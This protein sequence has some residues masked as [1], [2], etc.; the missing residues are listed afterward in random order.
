M[1][2]LRLLFIIVCFQQQSTSAQ[3][4]KPVFKDGEFSGKIYQNYTDKEGYTW[5]STDQGVYR[6]DS[7]NFEHFTTADGL[8]H[9]EVFK[10]YQDT[11]MRVWMIFHNGDVCYYYQGNIFNKNNFSRLQQLPKLSSS[12]IESHNSLYFVLKTRKYNLDTNFTIST[13]TLGTND[14]IKVI[15]KN[16]GNGVFKFSGDP[17][18]SHWNILYN[19]KLKKKY[20]ID[21]LLGDTLYHMSFQNILYGVNYPFYSP[22]KYIIIKYYNIEKTINLNQD[23][24]LLGILDKE[25][26]FIC[27]SIIY[28]TQKDNRLKPINYLK[29][30]F[31]AFQT[32]INNSS[33][34][35]IQKN[36]ENLGKSSLDKLTNVKVMSTSKSI[37]KVFFQDGNLWRIHNNY[38]IVENQSQKK[39][40][41]PSSLAIDKEQVM[42]NCIL[43]KNSTL[44]TTASSLYKITP[45]KI[46]LLISSTS[47]TNLSKG[48]TSIKYTIIKKPYLYVSTKYGV[49]RVYKNVIT[50]LLNSATKSCYIDRKNRFW[51]SNDNGI[52]YTKDYDPKIKNLKKLKTRNNISVQAY[53][54]KEDKYGNVLIA[55][56]DGVYL[57]HDNDSI[58]HLNTEHGLTS[59]ECKKIEVDTDGSLWIATNKGVNHFIYLKN[60]EFS[61]SP[62]NFFL[63]D[64][65]ILSS[66]IR[67][68]AI[69]GDSIYI[70]SD[71]GLNLVVDKNWKVDSTATIR[72]HINKLYINGEI[73][74]STHFPKLAYDQN[75]LQ[76]DFSAIYYERTDRMKV[77]YN[78]IVDGDTTAF[79]TDDRE[80]M[81]QSLGSGDYKLQIYAY[82]QD[83][84]YIKSNVNELNFSIAPQFYKTWWFIGSIMLLIIGIVAYIY[85]INTKRLEEEKNRLSIEKDLSKFKLEALKAEMNPHFVFNCLNSIKEDMMKEDFENSQYYL[86][87]LAKLIRQALYST[88]MEFHSIEE[89]IKFIDLYIELE[90]KRH[91]FQ[92][93][94]IKDFSGFKSFHYNIPTMLLQPFFENAIR[95]GKIGQLDYTGKLYFKIS[96]NDQLFTIEIKD[97]GIGLKEAKKIQAKTNSEHKSMAMDIINERIALYKESNDMDIDISINELKNSEYKTQV[98]I[99]VL[100]ESL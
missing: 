11:K 2:I 82:D 10:V 50:K 52:F 98:L 22:S 64:D 5:I 32:P 96:E 61:P 1:K 16:T 93:E 88:K 55:T 66:N 23:G 25:Y 40:L 37:H 19:Y 24:Y 31:Y 81:L 78:L 62:I 87:R 76:I 89:E 70:A 26:L 30:S 46:T 14:T 59:N 36:Q 79:E 43:N 49:Y 45:S 57:A 6:W 86:S 44:L 65:G 9:N 27:D 67:D 3:L 15:H 7:K 94:Y 68:F 56:N 97:N 38:S 58:S 75:S 29:S 41:F 92:F 42:Y 35:L 91:S 39:I 8:P 74:D 28:L 80:I 84:P 47:L 17:F 85:Y 77:F 54:F 60:G 51:L 90:Q 99:N 72:V 33:L 4:L 13:F 18:I 73:F 20:K 69:K 21:N 34:L 48:F 95:H 53:D 100:K 12:V 63:Q 71:K 83:Y